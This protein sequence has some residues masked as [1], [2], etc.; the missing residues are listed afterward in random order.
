MK[1]VLAVFLKAP[2]P[3]AVKTRLV[4]A[5]GPDAPAALY[6]AL[7]E[8]AVEGTRPRAGEYEQLLFFA[9][10]EA[11]AEMEAWFPGETWIAQDG[12]DL[13]VRMAA[14]FDEAFRR[15]ADRA[16]IVGSDVPGLTSSDV[17]AAL[18]SLADHDL[19]LG[20]ALDGGYWLIALGRPA[21][22]LFQGIAW[23]SAS[24]F[25]AT[26]ERAAVLGLTVRVLEPRRDV[27]T[28]DD[29]RAEWARIRPLVPASVAEAVERALGR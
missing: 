14:A 16:A 28:L 12:L 5:L 17:V 23:G 10:A 15:G 25:A 9:P 6:R 29:V 26:M 24:V 20:P 27:D 8:S 11:R 18:D 7:A 3:G 21:P 1:A 13:G 19:A 2:R 22:A 4:P